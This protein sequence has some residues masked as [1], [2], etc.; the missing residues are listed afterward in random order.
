MTN[1]SCKSQNDNDNLNIDLIVQ[2]NANLLPPDE[3]RIK[4]VSAS[5]YPDNRR[6]KVTVEVTPFRE[7]PNLE[8]TLLDADGRPVANTSAI[9]LMNFTTSYVM[10]LRGIQDSAGEYTIRVQVF[11]DS[12]ND[13]KDSREATLRIPANADARE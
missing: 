11:Y 7:R 1:N 2:N 10:H 4:N 8:I 12:L 6:V 3:I 5:P 9:G 13:T